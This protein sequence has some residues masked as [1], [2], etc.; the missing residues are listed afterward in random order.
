MVDRINSDHN[1]FKRKVADHLRKNLG[2][3]VTHDKIKVK[4]GKI[5]VNI[6]TINIPRFQFGSKQMGGVSIGDGDEGESLFP[7]TED[8]SGAGDSGHQRSE[9]VDFTVQELTDLIIDDLELPKLQPSSKGSVTEKRLKYNSISKT[10]P[11]S[12]IHRKRTLKS[13]LLRSMASGSYVPG[14]P[15]IPSRGGFV[16]KHPK[17]IIMPSTDIRIIYLLDVSPSTRPGIEL[18][19]SEVF[20]LENIIDRLYNQPNARSHKEI[21]SNYVIHTDRAE[22]V[23][24]DLFF[25]STWR[26]GTKISSG[27]NIMMKILEEN[28]CNNTYVFQYT[29][30]ENLDSDNEKSVELLTKILPQVNVFGYTQMNLGNSNQ[31]GSFMNI[32]KYFFQE[33]IMKDELILAEIS[34]YEGKD[35]LDSI[36]EKM[37]TG[38]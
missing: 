22:E 23:T 25:G 1:R 38:R 12:Q 20:W 16:F 37:K 2:D 29:D 32:L 7:G 31:K 18:I 13:F 33:E 26:G 27:Y 19:R 14:D 11:N 9:D 36:W 15:I 6:P 8:D 35:I 3:Y 21:I 5:T 28:S 34:G 30:G 10:G 24:K 17:T 4:G